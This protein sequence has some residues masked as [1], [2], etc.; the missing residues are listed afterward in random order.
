MN[1]HSHLVHKAMLHIGT[2][3]PHV[4]IWKTHTGE[5]YTMESVNE[6]LKALFLGQ[7]D[8]KN[9][10]T[11]FDK[12]K[13]VMDLMRRIKFGQVGQ[14]DLAG[15]IKPNGRAV[16]IEVKTGTGRLSKEQKLF[17]DMVVSWGCIH[18][19]LRSV[20]DLEALRSVA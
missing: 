1:N 5:A 3:Y 19:E 9:C 10:P 20:E 16:F 15:I 14:T 7:I 4:R 12:I 17:R 11:L 6:A 8:F 13:K 2:H 18:I